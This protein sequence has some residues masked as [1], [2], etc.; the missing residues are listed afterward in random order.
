MRRLC[1]TV[2]IGNEAKITMNLKFRDGLSHMLVILVNRHEDS[3]FSKINKL[4]SPTNSNR[5][6]QKPKCSGH[7]GLRRT[8]RDEAR[9][10]RTISSAI[11]LSFCVYSSR[12]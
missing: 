5:R 1:Q 7:A 12:G 4:A 2:S 8:N 3:L 11:C 10:N 9:K 6:N